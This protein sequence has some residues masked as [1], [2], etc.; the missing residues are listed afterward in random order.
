MLNKTFS[1][2]KYSNNNEKIQNVKQ[3][4]KGKNYKKPNEIIILKKSS[5]GLNGNI[6]IYHD[7]KNNTIINLFNKSDLITKND[8]FF[9]FLT[10]GKNAEKYYKNKEDNNIIKV[11]MKIW[12]N[13]SQGLNSSI[14]SNNINSKLKSKNSV[15]NNEKKLMNTIKKKS[16]KDKNYIRNIKYNIASTQC[17]F[18]LNEKINFFIKKLKNAI[19]SK[20]FKL[21]KQKYYINNNYIQK[22]ITYKKSKNKSKVKQDSSIKKKINNRDMKDIKYKNSNNC[23]FLYDKL[24]ISILGTQP[25]KQKM[26]NNNESSMQKRKKAKINSISNSPKKVSNKK[27][28]NRKNILG[29]MPNKSTENRH[30]KSDKLKKNI[31]SKSKKKKNVVKSNPSI[32][33]IK[34]SQKDKKEDSKYYITEHKSSFISSFNLNNKPEQNYGNYLFKEKEYVKYKNN[35]SDFIL[36]DILNPG[37]VLKKGN[38]NNYGYIKNIFNLWKSSVTKQKI[39]NNL[40]YRSKL[41]KFMTKFKNI[42]IKK[43]LNVLNICILYKFFYKYKDKYFRW[44]IV[45]NIRKMKNNSSKSI[46]KRAQDI[47]K[48]DIINN[49]NINNYIYSDYNKYIKQ[50][51]KNPVI[52]SKL[53]N[54]KT[55]TDNFISELNEPQKDLNIFEEK[56]HNID[57]NSE[58]KQYNNNYNNY[59]FFNQ[60][61]REQNNINSDLFLNYIKDEDKY[62]KS[63]NINIKKLKMKYSSNINDSNKQERSQIMSNNMINKVNQLSMVLNLLQQHKTKNINLLECFHKWFLFSKTNS[64]QKNNE[65]FSFSPE[66]SINQN[67]INQRYSNNTYSKKIKNVAFSS[68]KKKKIKQESDEYSPIKEITNFRSNTVKKIAYINYCNSS[69]WINKRDNKNKFDINSFELIEPNLNNINNNY[70]YH[71]KIINISNISGIY[72][73]FLENNNFIDNTKSMNIT[74]SSFYSNKTK[75]LKISKIIEEKKVSFKNVNRIEEREIKF[76]SYKRN[77][78]SDKNY[79]LNEL[80]IKKTKNNSNEDLFVNKLKNNIIKKTDNYIIDYGKNLIRN[81]NKLLE[82]S[83]FIKKSVTFE[84]KKANNFIELNEKENFSFSFSFFEPKYNI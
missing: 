5:S 64:S 45:N 74:S 55:K 1:K 39:I 6:S 34:K 30:K 61:D 72:N 10:S 8:L 71:K 17:K 29:Q 23:L 42:F 20:Y 15:S 50:K 51:N 47:N 65:F 56:N 70:V 80:N 7:N 49:I 76:S 73:C 77:N 60:T 36:I 46:N 32:K 13:N 48:F 67:L 3:S 44:K 52:L 53:I 63:I 57:I 9:S 31:N 11:N 58:R 81:R 82:E 75:D 54:P 21:M 27:Q 41:N 59:F 69:N 25:S 83:K 35:N 24:G 18:L 22:T 4:K 68:K 79:K 38:D 62:C 26:I 66:K 78:S 33:A 16:E 43:L 12:K 40:I 2:I 28:L 37:N 14:S 19:Y 84:F